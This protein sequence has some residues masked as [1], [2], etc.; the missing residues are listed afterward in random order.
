MIWNTFFTFS[1]PCIVIYLL[2]KDKQDA[3]FFLNLLL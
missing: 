3:F 1:G 2:N